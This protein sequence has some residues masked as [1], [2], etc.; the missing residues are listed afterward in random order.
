MGKKKKIINIYTLE[1]F[2]SMTEAA[3]EIGV[4]KVSIFETIHYKVKAKGTRFEYLD[5]W[6]QWPPQEKE[7]F[8]K[9]N[10][11]YFYYKEETHDRNN[12]R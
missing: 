6:I 7:K 10:N 11:I 1:V 8:S 4:S 12:N 3:K 5:E 9:R 2:D